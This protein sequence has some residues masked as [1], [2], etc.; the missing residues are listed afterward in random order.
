MAE[1][2]AYSESDC[3]RHIR[4]MAKAV[5]YLHT[6]GIVHRDLKPEN[7]LLSSSDDTKAIVKVFYL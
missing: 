2:G 1:K 6:H 7:V 3:A 5:D 4:D